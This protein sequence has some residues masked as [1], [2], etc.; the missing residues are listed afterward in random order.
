[1]T[2]EDFL[3]N[4]TSPKTALDFDDVSDWITY[5]HE[6]IQFYITNYTNS[7]IIMLVNGETT[8]RST[9]QLLMN[10]PSFED[11]NNYIKLIE[12]FD[13]VV[14]LGLNKQLK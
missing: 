6:I 5:I 1:M 9:R 11:K 8:K 7:I 12:A 2:K 14:T 10:K 4:I 3:N 13:Y